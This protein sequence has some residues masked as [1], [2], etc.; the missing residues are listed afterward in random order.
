MK[1]PRLLMASVFVRLRWYWAV[2]M[3]CQTAE[4]RRDNRIR[5]RFASHPDI[6]AIMNDYEKARA[7]YNAATTE[8]HRFIRMEYLIDKCEARLKELGQEYGM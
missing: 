2:R 6:V 8:Y 3:F 1:S 4:Q 5:K 7:Y